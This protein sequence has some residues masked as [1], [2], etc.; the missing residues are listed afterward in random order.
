M[1]IWGS[2]IVWCGDCCDLSECGWCSVS[3]C[4]KST[5]CSPLTSQWVTWTIFCTC[6]NSYP[7]NC[8][9]WK[10]VLGSNSKGFIR[11]RTSWWIRHLN[12]GTE[13]I[14]W[15][16]KC[17]KTRSVQSV[18]CYR[19][20]VHSLRESNR[21]IKCDWNRSISIWRRTGRNRWRCSIS[22]CGCVV[23]GGSVFSCVVGKVRC[24]VMLSK[25]RLIANLS[26]EKPQGQQ[27][28]VAELESPDAPAGDQG[29]TTPEEWVF[30]KDDYYCT[31]TD[32]ID[33][34]MASG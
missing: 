32:W 7:E 20:C 18:G 21:D 10:I 26:V 33:L 12:T 28:G 11:V 23:V 8:W 24:C 22:S 9:I 34:I 14:R 16:L 6:C 13:T 2:V 29:T 19:T 30:P 27:T 1:A 5:W 3:I 17:S 25:E 31:R 15:N 4:L